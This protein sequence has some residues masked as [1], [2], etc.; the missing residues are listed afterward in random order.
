MVVINGT[1]HTFLCWYWVAAW[2]PADA[3]GSQAS[4]VGEAT[5]RDALGPALLEPL[6][7]LITKPHR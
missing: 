6:L 2:S 1:V 5:G 4:A 3:G 7:A